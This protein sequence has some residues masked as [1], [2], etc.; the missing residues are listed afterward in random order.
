MDAVAERVAGRGR[1]YEPAPFR[2]DESAFR[3]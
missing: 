1:V 2:R 3:P